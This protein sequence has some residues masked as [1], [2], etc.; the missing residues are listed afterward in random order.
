ML[1]GPKTWICNSHLPEY[2][3]K[4]KMRKVL[5]THSLAIEEGRHKQTWLPRE[6]R[7]CCDLGAVETEL[8][9]LTERAKYVE[10]RESLFSKFCSILFQSFKTKQIKKNDYTFLERRIRPL[11]QQHLWHFAMTWGA[12]SEA[13]H[14]KTP[15]PT[16]S[17]FGI[18]NVYCP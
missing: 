6:E 7:L 11:W 10:I 1:F 4:K 3:R 13:T 5:A 17:P 15:T 18:I 16:P 9:F 12:A 8:H 2:S 14:N